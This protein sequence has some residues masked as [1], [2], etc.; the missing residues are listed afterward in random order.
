MALDITRS[1]DPQAP[2]LWGM[3]AINDFPVSL[4]YFLGPKVHALGNSV[5]SQNVVYMPYVIHGILG[6]VWWYILPRIFLPRRLGGV[7]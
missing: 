1:T 3:F 4:L 7:W 2:L 6:T 5:A